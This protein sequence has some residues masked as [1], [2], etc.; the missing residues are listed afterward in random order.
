MYE[1]IERSMESGPRW[2]SEVITLPEAPTE[3]QILFYR[4]PHECIAYLLGNPTFK[5]SIGYE[6]LEVFE[7]DG[8]TRVYNEMFTGRLWNE[9]QVSQQISQTIIT[10]IN[11]RHAGFAPTRHHS[12]WRC[13]LDR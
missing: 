5:G 4:D 11:T 3:P 12:D 6:A 13:A 2:R 1:R 7:A 8:N 10:S 9:T